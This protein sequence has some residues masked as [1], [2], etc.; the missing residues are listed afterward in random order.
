MLL[1]IKNGY[2]ITET[3]TSSLSIGMFNLNLLQFYVRIPYT[4]NLT[5]ITFN[6]K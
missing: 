3:D 1:Q 6:Y 4:Y 5:K 2:N